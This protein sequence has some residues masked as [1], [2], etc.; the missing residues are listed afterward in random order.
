MPVGITRFDKGAP[1]DFG[2]LL[3]DTHGPPRL[4]LVIRPHQSLTP[5]GFVWFIGLTA[6]FMALPLIMVLGRPVLWGLLPFALGAIAAIWWGLKRSWRDL[7]LREDLVIWDG[8]M[9]LTHKAPSKAALIWEVNP[10]WVRLKR[11]SEGAKVP[12]YLTMKAETR[13][14]EIGAFLSPAERRD[15]HA[16][17]E[18]EI[19][20]ITGA[21]HLG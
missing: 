20:P 11:I 6:G 19:L 9:R 1:E 10:Y 17:L 7:E 14:V 12:D 8:W 13:E 18:R 21:A 5:P 15:L 4:H 2:A 3:H 16:L